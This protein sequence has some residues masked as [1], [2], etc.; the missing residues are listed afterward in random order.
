MTDGN[1][2]QNDQSQTEDTGMKDQGEL[3]GE[4]IED[5]D[6]EVDSDTSETS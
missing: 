3:G 1:K 6:T 2:N 4:A 5:T